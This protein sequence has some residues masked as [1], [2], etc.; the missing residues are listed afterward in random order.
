MVYVKKQI[1]T[2]VSFEGVMT[3]GFLGLGG[4]GGGL[5]NWSKFFLME[6]K[7]VLRG[8]SHQML[9]FLLRNLQNSYLSYS[10]K[11]AIYEKDA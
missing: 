11:Q 5:E 1:H 7:G 6:K 9:K 8:F 2:Y 4:G 3:S 10:G